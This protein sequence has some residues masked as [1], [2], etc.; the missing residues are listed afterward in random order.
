MPD[1]GC[2]F[3]IPLF[4]Y[5]IPNHIATQNTYHIFIGGIVQGVGFRPFV[6]RLAVQWGLN[7]WVNNDS[8]GVHIEI[9]AP[10]ATV[11]QFYAALEHNAPANALITH[12]AIYK[13]ADAVFTGFRIM[14][15]KKADGFP[16]VLISP[17]FSL[18]R[19]CRD[20]LHDPANRR[21]QYAFTTC[22]VCGP[23][24]SIVQALPYDRA[25]TTMQAFRMCPECNREYADPGHRRFH[26][27]TNSCLVCGIHITMIDA[28]GNS[29]AAG[30]GQLAAAIQQQLQAGKIAAVKAVGGYLLLC[31]AGNA[32]AVQLL[33]R[34]KQRPAKP[35]AVM[36]ADELQAA[37][38]AFV[39]DRERAALLSPAAPIVL[40]RSR[41]PTD[42]ALDDIAPGLP[43][44]GAMLP[45]APLL[46]IIA[47]QWGRPLV[48]TSANISNSPVIYRDEDALLYLKEVADCIVLHN[49]PI[50]TPQDD[51]VIRFAPHLNLPII[52]RRSRG[53]APAFIG[54]QAAGSETLLATGAFMK[55]S[56]TLK[57]AGNTYVSQYLGSTGTLEA[58]QAYVA[59]MNSLLQVLHSKPA[60]VI[61]DKHPGYFSSQLAGELAAA[62]HCSLATVQ[63]HKA[64]FA[65]VLAENNLLHT[66][67]PVLGVIWDGTGWGDDGQVWG[68]EFF[69][70][71]NSTISRY[72]HFDY[73]PQLMNDKM[74]REPRL[75]ALAACS[76]I[77]QAAGL[78]KK[79]FS[80]AEWDLYRRMLQ[81]EHPLQCCSM[82]RI[83]DAV[84]SLLNL[85]NVQGY[86][87]EAAMQLQALAETYTSLNGYHIKETYCSDADPD[88]CLSVNRLFTAIVN[89]IVLGRPA[90]FV[91][92][93]FHYSLVQVIR[94]V[95]ARQ[96]IAGIAFSGGV[97]QNSLLA[98]M[99]QYLLSGSYPLYFHRQLSPNDEN[100][101]FGQMLYYDNNL[102]SIKD[103]PR[104][105]LA[106]K[107][108]RIAV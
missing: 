97:F 14:P 85:C 71:S 83:F 48:A 13:A 76:G 33:R 11:T 16:A 99:I 18:C 5:F 74:A 86:E 35:L 61:A 8:D 43:S 57:A 59:A 39:D 67:Q 23:R 64:H 29:I 40:L 37:A 68:A 96:P 45:A 20:E 54:Y 90:A 31:D 70:Y 91:A 53:M 84:A 17:D 79:K 100:I 108:D 60:V 26:S 7:G 19:Q 28:A 24:Y 6:L 62:N 105:N 98:D 50:V 10:E 1:P 58:Q 94:L 66:A 3:S 27:Q 102:D 44:I 92:A 72:C 65:A 55:S 4:I 51:S 103:A 21:Y 41:R 49:R 106:G 56:F 42:L 15:S 87:G 78:L 25:H 77:E 2:L 107:S 34:R 88:N 73:F 80:A 101:S 81:A 9:N 104:K 22:T 30:N 63:H 12:H 82:G 93:K 75:S 47:R 52:L 32:A 95:A 89:D 36:F 46:E 69:V 38:Y